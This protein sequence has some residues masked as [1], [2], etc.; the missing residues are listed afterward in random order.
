M[1]NDVQG[2]KNRLDML[3]IKQDRIQPTLMSSIPDHSQIFRSPSNDR[4][5]VTCPSPFAPKIASATV[6]VSPKQ[7]ILEP[8]SAYG[9]PIHVTVATVTEEMACAQIPSRQ[10]HTPAN[11]A[12]EFDL[13]SK[14][15]LDDL[16]SFLSLNWDGP[17]PKS[18]ATST[19]KP[20]LDFGIPSLCCESCVPSTVA[21]SEP[22]QQPLKVGN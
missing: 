12:P 16:E 22:N 8:V 17:Q 18:I 7:P 10:L 5:I 19:S 14:I 20:C 15:S 21:P 2:L 13:E 9:Q 11:S 3:Y 1:V 6:Y 4:P